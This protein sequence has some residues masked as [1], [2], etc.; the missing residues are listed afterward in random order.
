M[1]YTKKVSFNEVSGK[2]TASI[3]FDLENNRL[4]FSDFL[5]VMKQ[6]CGFWWWLRPSRLW[7]DF[8]TGKLTVT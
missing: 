6:E 3:E 1:T 2:M 8:S 5:E 7:L 4:R